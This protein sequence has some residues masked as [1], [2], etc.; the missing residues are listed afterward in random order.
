[1]LKGVIGYSILKVMNLIFDIALKC[2][3]WLSVHIDDIHKPDNSLMPIVEMQTMSIGELLLAGKQ[4][5]PDADISKRTIDV[6][7]LVRSC[8]LSAL[9]MV[10]DPASDSDRSTERVK[11]L[12]NLLPVEETEGK[13]FHTGGV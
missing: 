1:M 6:R 4:V 10:K 12:L 3:K 11:I 8:L 7:K 5:P 2:G 9:S 13:P